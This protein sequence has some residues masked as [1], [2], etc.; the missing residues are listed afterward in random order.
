MNKGSLAILPLRAFVRC[1][2]AFTL[3]FVICYLQLLGTY[4]RFVLRL[5]VVSGSKELGRGHPTWHLVLVPDHDEHDE[6]KE[7]DNDDDFD[8]KDDKEEYD[9]E[10]EED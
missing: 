5:H 3:V 7:E 4:I 10:E 8:E 1:V 2:F 6:E 9:N